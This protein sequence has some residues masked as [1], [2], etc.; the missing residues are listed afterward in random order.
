MSGGVKAARKRWRRERKKKIRVRIRFT[1]N[2]IG[3]SFEKRRD[4]EEIERS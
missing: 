4:E 3:D 2:A 1:G